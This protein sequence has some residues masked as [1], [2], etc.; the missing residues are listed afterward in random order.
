MLWVVGLA[1]FVLILFALQDPEV[2]LGT[3]WT[4][5]VATAGTIIILFLVG[6]F[7]QAA[8]GQL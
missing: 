8:G 3:F 1:V 2:F 4:L 7:I 5:V 6:L